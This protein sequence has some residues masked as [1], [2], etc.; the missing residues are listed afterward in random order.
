MLYR[1]VSTFEEW[2]TVARPLLVAGVDTRAVE[3]GDK[4]HSSAMGQ[5]DLNPS[6]A[7]D[8]IAPSGSNSAISLPSGLMRLLET[9]ACFRHA[10]RWELMYR[11]AYRT[12]RENPRL[13]QDAA[14][15]DVHNASLMER[16]IRRD[17]HK[18]HAFVRF[19]EFDYP[20]GAKS[21]FAWFIPE[22]EILRRAS[23]FF[24]KRF[25]NMTWT[26]ATPDG[27]AVWDRRELRFVDT[28][29]AADQ[30][31]ADDQEKLWRTYYRS[32]CNVARIN[33]AAMMREMPQRYWR[34]LPEAAEIGVLI[35]DG[36]ANFA[37]RH[38][39]AES[40]ALNTSKAVQHA[41]AQLPT[42]GDG[43]QACRRCDLWQH[44]TQAVLGDGDVRATL[45]LVG[46]QPGDTED[47]R[48][49]PFV[50]PAGAVLDDAITEAELKR[51]NLYI[52]NAVKHF[53][54][55][56]RGKRRMHSKPGISEINACSV[57]L[58]QEISTVRPLVIVALGT[59][60]LR[61]LMDIALS[62]DAARLM[63]L[64]HTDGARV[65]ATYHPA[66]ILR[67]DAKTAEVMRSN[68]V[69]T[70][71]Q[72]R[73]YAASLSTQGT[74]SRGSTHAHELRALVRSRQRVRSSYNA[75]GLVPAENA[76]RWYLSIPSK[77]SISV[78]SRFTVI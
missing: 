57:W 21:Y 13:L 43:P 18:M 77:V 34:H 52:T 54:W 32:I 64:R 47:L 17:C 20:A 30:P 55:L 50:G 69:A 75:S 31:R 24:I 56:P 73:A 48:G 15:P 36:L 37:S 7:S 19:R 23:S 45:M 1:S 16:A 68:L 25:T 26:L 28:A 22:H 9:I 3:W 5:L 49:R 12:L 61:S 71:I 4:F 63:D 46:E 78:I 2:R 53:K 60:A 51:S 14:D 11:L 65:L 8:A 33:P 67:A 70:L 62:I 58:N 27:A 39:D 35:R 40:Q 59:T 42:L 76:D 10:S 38:S 44:A 29:G 74:W 66:A 41:L 6:P 72:A